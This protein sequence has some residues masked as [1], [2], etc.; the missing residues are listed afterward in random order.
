MP[1]FIF[2]YYFHYARKMV[3]VFC[4]VLI[5]CVCVLLLLLLFFA[6]LLFWLICVGIFL[7]VDDTDSIEYK[8]GAK[9]DFSEN[10]CTCESILLFFECFIVLYV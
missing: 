2:D 4:F 7:T 3:C 6:S 1:I 9:R 8:W 10:H 5:L